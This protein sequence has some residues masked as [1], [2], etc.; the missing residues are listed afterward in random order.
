MGETRMRKLY[1]TKRHQFEQEKAKLVLLL[2]EVK[3]IREVVKIN[4][5]RIRETNLASK[6]KVAE[7][8]HVVALSHKYARTTALAEQRIA[9]LRHHMLKESK[10]ANR[11]S[12]REHSKLIRISQEVQ[13]VKSRWAKM[14]VKVRNFAHRLHELESSI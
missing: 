10:R 11:R 6:K 14:K 12:K 3:S 2:H 1:V 8:K 4:H 9:V 13:R 7:L 5:R